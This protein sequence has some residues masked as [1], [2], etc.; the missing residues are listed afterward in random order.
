MTIVYDTS[1]NSGLVA[2]DNFSFLHTFIATGQVFIGLIVNVGII[3]GG[4]TMD[5]GSYG[6]RNLIFVR[7][8]TNGA[9]RLETWFLP[10]YEYWVAGEQVAIHLTASGDVIATASSYFYLGG[11]GAHGGATGTGDPASLAITPLQRDS[12]VFSSMLTQTTSGV[13]NADS[14]NSR[15]DVPSASGTLMASSKG[16]I[17]TPVSTT[18]QFNGITAGHAW[19]QSSVELL[20]YQDNPP[21]IM[22]A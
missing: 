19:V 8:D 5:Y 4:G 12:V 1:T 11:I 20:T 22:G 17:A 21:A 7:A 6:D 15:A 9:Y 3:S 13:L 16:P 14:Q 18:L 10:A 2:S